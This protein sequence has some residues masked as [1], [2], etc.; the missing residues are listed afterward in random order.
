M[1]EEPVSDE[2]FSDGPIIPDDIRLLREALPEIMT[3]QSI[4][5]YCL[6]ELLGKGGMGEVYRA[7]DPH[8]GRD[9]AIKILP[10][11]SRA[12]RSVSPVSSVRRACSPP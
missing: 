8:L 12:T 9:V 10:A 5:D 6:Q 3:G 4:G 1:L 7:Q 11:H 2:A